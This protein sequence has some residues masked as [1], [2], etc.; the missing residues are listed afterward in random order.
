MDLQSS[1]SSGTATLSIALNLPKARALT[2]SLNIVYDSGGGNGPYGAGA[3]IAIASITRSTARGVPSYTDADILVFSETGVLVEKGHWAGDRWVAQIRTETDASGKSWRVQTYIP[4]RDGGLPLIEQW[5]GLDDQ[6]SHWR[7]VSGDN[8]ESLYGV[9]ASARIQDPA[10]P[11]RIFQWLLESVTDAKGNRAQY[12][13]KADDDAQAGATNRYIEKILYGNYFPAPPADEA[14]AY[15]LVF[16]YGEYSLEGLDRPGADPYTPVRPWSER[17]DAFSSFRSGFEIRTRRL[18]R[19]VLTFL[20][21]P[22]ELGALRCLNA[23][24]QLQYAESPYLSCLSTLLSTGY[25][26]LADG[27]YQAQ[28]LPPMRWRFSAFDPPPAPRFAPLTVQGP[29]GLPGYLA[30]GAYQPVDLQGAGLPGFLQSDGVATRYYEP[31]GDGRYGAPLA[32]S[33][34]PD[35]G[36]LANPALALADLDSNGQLELLVSA[37]SATGFYQHHDDGGWSGRQALAHIPILYGAS[38]A[39]T[40]DLNGGG[41]ADL[42][43]TSATELRHYPSLGVAGFGP[44]RSALRPDGFPAASANTEQ[45]AAVFAD[46]FGDGL[47]HRVQVRNGEVAVWPCLGHGRYGRRRLLANAPQFGATMSASRIYFADVDGSGAADIVYAALDHMLVFRNQSGNGY[48][49]PLR[50]PLPVT[51]SPLDQI[52]FADIHGNGTTAIV[53]TRVSPEVQHWACDLCTEASGKPYLLA[54]TDNGLGA[55]TAVRYA[56]S[57]RFFLADK[58]AGRPWVTRLPFPVQVVTQIQSADAVSEVSFTRRY[59][60]HDGYFDPVAR[61][62]RGFGMIENW[63]AQAYAPFADAPGGG[64]PVAR[65]DD[66]LRVPPTLIRSWYCV[67]AYELAPAVAAQNARAYFHGDPKAAPPLANVFDP[68][69]GDGAALRQA[70]AALA[71]S[72]IHTEIYAEDGDPA[73]AALPYTVTDAC[74]EVRLL[75]PAGPG[76]LCA[77]SVLERQSIQYEYDRCPA[78]PRMRQTFLLANTLH[79]PDAS[80]TQYLEQRCIVLLGRRSQSDAAVYPEQREIQVTLEESLQTR[81]LSPFRLIGAQIQQQSLELGGLAAPASGYYAWDEIHAQARAAMAAPI[82]YGQPFKPGEPAARL[83]ARNRHWYWNEAQDAALPLGQATGRALT[84]HED[85]ASFSDFWLDAV[86]GARASAEQLRDQA[87]LASDG[88]GYWIAPGPVQAYATPMQP[89]LYYQ[90]TGTLWSAPGAAPYSQ[91]SIGYDSPY[92][93]FPLRTAEYASA[94]VSLATEALIDYQSQAPWQLTD[95]NGVVQQVLYDARGNVVAQSVFKPAQGDRP[96]V[97]DMD[98]SDYVWRDQASFDSVIADP[99]YYLQGAGAYYFYDP[100]AASETPARPA[101]AITVVRSRYVSDNAAEAPIEVSIEFTDGF[102][103]VV[104][105][106]RECEAGEAVLRDARS[107][108]L[109]DGQG[110]AC[111]GM[112][113]RRWQVS[114][115]TVYNNKGLPA[116]QYLPYYSN[117][118]AYEAQQDLAD[119]GLVP[120]PRITRYDPLGRVI[121][122]DTPKGFFSCTLYQPWLMREYDENDTVLDAP[123]YRIFMAQYPPDPTPAQIEEKEVLEQAA[124]CYNTPLTYALDSA[125][126]KC[127]MIA[128]N[129]GNVPPDAFAAIVAGGAISSEQLWAALIQAGYL[130]TTQ[131]PAGTWIS[132][133]FQPYQ[134]GF[135][136]A[137]PAPFDAYAAAAC[138][139]LTQACLTSRVDTD[140]Y[141][142]VMRWADPR[143]FLANVSTGSDLANFRYAYPMASNQ[144]ALVDSADAGARHILNSA[145]DTPVLAWDGMGRIQNKT[146]DGLQRLLQTQITEADGKTRLSE[147]LAYGEGRPDAAAANLNGQLWRLRD[148]AGEMFYQDYSVQGQPRDTTRQFAQDPR[149]PIDWAGA[150]PLQPTVYRTVQGYDALRR[151]ISEQTPDGSVIGWRYA[152]SGRLA[153]VTLQQGSATDVFVTNISYN[154]NDQRE[155]VFFG[156]QAIQT[157]SYEASTERLLG[158]STQR[159]ATGPDGVPRDPTVQQASYAY[160][161]VGN[162][163]RSHDRTAEHVFRGGAQPQA[164]GAY[165]YDALYRLNRA[166]GLQHPDIQA[167]THLTGFMQ[168]LYAELCP[169][170][171]PGITLEPYAEQY[172]YDDSGNLVRTRHDAA[173]ASF[174]RDNPVQ[175]NSNRLAGVPYDGNGNTLSTALLEPTTLDWDER[176]NFVGTGKVAKPD[177][178]SEQVWMSYDFTNTLAQRLMERSAQAGGPAVLRQTQYTIGSYVL[179]QTTQLDTGLTES[180]SSLRIMNGVGALVVTHDAQTP[181]GP[182]RRYQLDDKLGSVSVELD[183]QAGLVSYEAFYP[184]GG[185]AIIAGNDPAQV[186]AKALRYSSKPCDDSTGFYYYGSRY[187]LSWQGRWLAP[188]PAGPADGANL[189]EFVNGNPLSYI[190]PNGQG[191]TDPSKKTSTEL[192]LDHGKAMWQSFLK[193]YMYT[194]ANA[195]RHAY[196]EAPKYLY[197]RYFSDET[198][199]QATRQAARERLEESKLLYYNLSIVLGLDPE[200]FLPASVISWIKPQTKPW[201]LVS[202]PWY[203]TPLH[204][205]LRAKISSPQTQGAQ[206]GSF[207]GNFTTVGT[208]LVLLRTLA[209]AALP[210][211]MKFA[212]SPLLIGQILGGFGRAE[213]SERVYAKYQQDQAKQWFWQR[214]RK[215]GLAGMPKTLVYMDYQES[216]TEKLWQS[217]TAEQAAT[218]LGSLLMMRFMGP[219][220]LGRFMDAWKAG[221]YSGSWR[222]TGWGQ[223][224]GGSGWKSSWRSGTGGSSSGS[225]SSTALVPVIPPL[226]LARIPPVTSRLPAIVRNRVRALM[227]T[228]NPQTAVTPYTPAPLPVPWIR[229]NGLRLYVPPNTALMAVQRQ[230]AELVR[231]LLQK[232]IK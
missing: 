14:Y 172:D 198:V 52:S 221:A 84:H 42:L 34:F 87:G 133:Q 209:M 117:I 93:L 175:A 123:Y 179:R 192:V 91:T 219:K 31:L 88:A 47:S 171:G 97:G 102:G 59:A 226:P 202:V 141:G 127:R 182:R 190:D 71:G 89:A 130:R 188:D 80:R 232:I 44:A 8:I 29:T 140:R 156:N 211:Y 110:Q 205:E 124:L 105:S 170:P 145:L 203:G 164:L 41:K 185:T 147:V 23:S 159:P 49:A 178:A 38:Q 101:N 180:A 223:G 40:V 74:F 187:Y 17:P 1:G 186:A 50:V 70:H 81:V 61:L 161:P 2:P 12:Q 197:K 230:Q 214:D 66:E 155:Q 72:L 56:S 9:S 28:P 77:F 126:Q 128:C 153:G 151:P 73:L 142:R 63:D 146:F 169:D 64:W 98:L 150:V 212:F 85:Q 112:A 75:Q 220:M 13:Y 65:V 166:T 225:G 201:G 138:A 79:D 104:E 30:P 36:N 54:A 165:R 6:I 24:T 51:L 227:T 114:G 215:Y 21:F 46:V 55:T 231:F 183:E 213:E 113:P 92:A 154:A 67:G 20:N 116:Q 149:L 224:W 48:S 144:A 196:I 18:C 131:V 210:P 174:Q 177:G 208:S 162:L 103:Q 136:L 118:A 200:S 134:P 222:W 94:D 195:P 45:T 57:T 58:Q 199:R 76:G 22:A 33:S 115:R 158:A 125:G 100:Q 111:L 53:I 4:Q 35:S 206:L 189:M 7:M 173:S 143:L 148:E 68:A 3:S 108:L 160:D 86:F 184:Y 5:T 218:F 43:F 191:K 25:G 26:R 121:R 163:A 78:D 96:R 95:S 204:N 10:D 139:L 109:R 37:G 122:V 157:L 119:A 120:P 99:A 32:P 19:G 132:E 60:Y 82:P 194:I 217:F 69:I 229:N 107:A 137:L 168:S 39:E 228:P 176:N 62:F 16:D 129:L 106:K 152:L 193:T 181:G 207:L 27:S 90:E 15:E 135:Q 83:V 216:E 167:D 11:T